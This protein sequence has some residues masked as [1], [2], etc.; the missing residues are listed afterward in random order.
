M[1]LHSHLETTMQASREVVQKTKNSYAQ[2]TTHY[3]MEKMRFELQATALAT[4]TL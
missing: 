3:W 4:I 1:W 2:S